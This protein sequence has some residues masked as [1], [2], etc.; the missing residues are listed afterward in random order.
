MAVVEAAFTPSYFGKL[1]SRGDFV[2]T[3]E[4]H[5]LMAMLDRWAGN[6]L[7]RLAADPGWKQLYDESPAMHFAFLGPRSRWVVVGHLQPSRDATQRRFPFLAASRFEVP[8]PHSFLARS[9][10]ALS[11]S[12]TVLGRLSRHAVAAEDA[13][14]ALRALAEARVVSS[15][16]ARTYDAAFND[17]MELQDVGSLQ[18]MLRISGHPDL[19]L[20]WLLPALGLLMQPLQTGGAARIDKALSLPLPRDVL[21]RPLVAA[22][23]ME[24]LAGFLGRMEFELL[25]LLPDPGASA[26][27]RL[28]VGFNGGDGRTIQAALDPRVAADAIVQ[29]DD[30]GWVEEQ[31]AEDYALN[32]LVSYIERDDLSLCSARAAFNQTFLGT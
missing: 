1:P 19:Q 7:E 18:A 9:P 20:R 13:G 27:P 11:R 26:A 12:W 31:V 5:H 6:G 23:W 15:A 28:L 24:L 3:T 17:F 2:R 30:A 25:L 32:K 8:E 21:Y 4:D 14:D 10:L 29:V 16:D 22:F